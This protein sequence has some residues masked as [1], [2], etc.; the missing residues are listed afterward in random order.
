MESVLIMCSSGVM[1][2][3]ELLETFSEKKS[4]IGIKPSKRSDILMY[5]SMKRIKKIYFQSGEAYINIDT[6]LCSK[7]ELDLDIPEQDVVLLRVIGGITYRGQSLFSL[8]DDISWK[9]GRWITPT[10]ELETIIY[11]PEYEI[12]KVYSM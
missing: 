10:T 4:W 3:G 9:D 7:P 5:F 11:V 2:S 6:D 1:Y 8:P 12:E